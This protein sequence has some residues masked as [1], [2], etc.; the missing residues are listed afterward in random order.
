MLLE[1]VCK[2]M[3]NSNLKKIVLVSLVAVILGVG[4]VVLGLVIG[5]NRVGPNEKVTSV[6]SKKTIVSGGS[7]GAV[8][9]KSLPSLTLNS[10]KVNLK[11]GE[12]F[13]TNIDIN[14]AGFPI[15]GA[16][17]VLTYDPALLELVGTAKPG[18][19]F[20]DELVLANRVDPKKGT[21]VLSLGTFTPFSGQGLFGSLE[22]AT[23][24]P[25]SAR[26]SFD[27]TQK[28]KIGFADANKEV[29]LIGGLL[30]VVV[31]I[32]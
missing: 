19:L 7:E 16:E 29:S 28:P 21:I 17:L 10:P 8:K 24:K 26:I 14:T 25:G 27:L 22:F 5:A 4:G 31:D 15:Y 18:K 20:V 3:N 2:T 1:I 23:K 13:A 12:K 30:P 9:P 6:E 32:K 11:V